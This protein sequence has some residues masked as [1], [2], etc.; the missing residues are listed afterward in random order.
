MS[1]IDRRNKNRQIAQNKHKSL[2]RETKIFD[3]RKGA[4]RIVAMVPL[5]EDGDAKAAVRQFKEVEGDIPEV[6]TITT[7]YVRLLCSEMKRLTKIELRGSSRRYN[8]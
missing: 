6:G 2:I 8:G 3:G 7:R 1:K 4:P 5:C